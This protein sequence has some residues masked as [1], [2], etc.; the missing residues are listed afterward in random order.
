MSFR[1]AS[2]DVHLM[3]LTDDSMNAIRAHPRYAGIRQSGRGF[4]MM[5][6]LVVLAV[7]GMMVGL[8]AVSFSFFSEPNIFEEPS[9]RIQQMSKV[10]LRS[11]VTEHRGVLVMFDKDGF[12]LIGTSGSEEGGSYRIPRGMRMEIFHWGGR[13]WEKAEGHVW[14]FGQQGICEPI[15]LRFVTDADSHELSFHPLTGAVIQ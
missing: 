10:A 11:A 4:T 8:G 14:P 12:R 15:K 3:F 9:E 2:L 1:W 7:M 13:R 5:E 6:L